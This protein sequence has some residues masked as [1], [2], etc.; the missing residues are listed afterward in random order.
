M[1]DDDLL[2]ITLYLPCHGPVAHQKAPLNDLMKIQ[3]PQWGPGLSLTKNRIQAEETP[4]VRSIRK[5]VIQ[6]PQ[7]SIIDAKQVLAFQSP[8]AQRAIA[9]ICSRSQISMPEANQ[10]FEAWHWESQKKV[11]NLNGQ[12]AEHGVR[13][14]RTTEPAGDSNTPYNFMV[15]WILLSLDAV[16]LEQH[17]NVSLSPGEVF[18]ANYP[19][20]LAE[21]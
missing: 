15:V 2:E 8:Q 5:L 17:Q 14:I 9:S 11:C 1:P 19:I 20:G 13:F 4:G 21:V 12:L 7:W 3:N 16:R 6:C 18:G 10:S